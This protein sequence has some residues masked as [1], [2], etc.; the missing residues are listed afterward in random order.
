MTGK[1]QDSVEATNNP[2]NLLVNVTEVT[3]HKA[4]VAVSVITGV[5]NH[6]AGASW[7]G[8]VT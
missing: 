4:R 8:L 7:G 1:S 3:Q 6:I 5:I 2:W